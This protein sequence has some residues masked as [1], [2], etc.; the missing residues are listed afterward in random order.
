MTTNIEITE[1]VEQPLLSRTFLKGFAHYDAA[2]PSFVEL[3]KQLATSLKHDES[4]VIVQRLEPVFGMRKSSLKAHVYK[5]KQAADTFSSKV[6]MRRNQP[7]V[8][9]MAAAAAEK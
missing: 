2:P 5:S 4:T 3:R 7:R 1:K 8:R 6:V 9:K